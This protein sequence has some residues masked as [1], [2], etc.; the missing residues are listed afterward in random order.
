MSCLHR[1]LVPLVFI[2]CLEGTALAQGP[3]SQGS[4]WG[5]VGGF[6]PW[7]P[8]SRVEKI[9][10]PL[11]NE[12]LLPLLDGSDLRIGIVRGRILSGDWGVTFIRKTMAQGSSANTSDGGGCDGRPGAGGA[13]VFNC[14]DDGVTVTPDAL[15]MTGFEVHK[16]VPFG[17]IKK[18]VQ[19]GLNFAG[20][21]G[22]GK[23]QF[24]TKGFRRTYSCSYPANVFPVG[25]PCVDRPVTGES[26]VPTGT[27]TGT[28][29]FAYMTSSGSN[30]VPL[31]KL[32]LAGAFIAASR[33]KVRVSGGL[34]YPG[35]SNFG[36]TAIYFFK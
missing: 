29:P 32:E 6:S 18:R 33:L 34:N 14:F 2:A 13:I 24:R 28:E 19:I 36:V 11:F 7:G 23:G 26:V 25:E 4:S 9:V 20:G 1:L 8:D 31:G 16:F 35:W 30:R 27:G 21:L 22:V 10:T 17:T 3:S 12:D 5:V 15:Q